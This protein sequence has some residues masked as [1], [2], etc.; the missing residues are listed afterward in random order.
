MLEDNCLIKTGFVGGAGYVMGMG[1]AIFM[2]A[3]E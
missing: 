1:I 3:L 2:N